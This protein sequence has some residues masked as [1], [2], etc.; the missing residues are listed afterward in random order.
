VVGSRFS[1]SLVKNT[2]LKYTSFEITS[3][4][5]LIIILVFTAIAIFDSVIVRYS[6]YT[7]ID[8]PVDLGVAIT[9]I[10][11][12]MY[13]VLGMSLLTS[14]KRTIS[15]HPRILAK[16]T[17]VLTY[18]HFIALSA[19]ILSVAII[20]VIILQIV[21]VE[22]YSIALLRVQT[23]L[24]HVVS[25][26]FL[27]YLVFRFAIW[28][29]TS[30]RDYIIFLYAVSCFLM[31]INIVVTL[32][33]LDSYFSSPLR[34]DRSWYSIVSIV[35]N[36]RVSPSTESLSVLFYALSLSSFLVMWIATSILLSQY[37]HR[38]GNVRYFLIM[39]VPV[40]YYIFPFQNYFGGTLIPLVL[41]S[42]VVFTILYIVIFSATNQ[43]GALVFSLSF[44]TSSKLLKDPQV[45]RAILMSS[46]GIAILFGSIQ[47]TP[48]QYRIYPPYGIITEAFMPLGAYA[49]LAG[50]FAA[51]TYI[52]QD[53][54]LRKE[55]YK[56]AFSQL[57]LFR[58]IG[59]SEMQRELEKKVQVVSR[60]TGS[61]EEDDRW[62]LK[63]EDAKQTLTEVLNEVYSKGNK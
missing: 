10:F 35:I 36:H 22:K 16:A 44:W 28:L 48:L 56:S 50:I 30:S 17:S 19:F 40:V 11:L 14:V 1:S 9:I 24:S 2:L 37:R 26:I 45:R 13:V 7:G 4:S 12:I 38:M 51:A 58:G 62:D 20:S 57:R 47:I 46:I 49:F 32:W 33:Y 55:F 3:R 29:K 6:A 52:S 23:Y 27:S 60:D 53:A 54:R 21:F 25:I 34:P 63:E 5:S 31:A 43:V 59:I 41:T 61:L 42:N 39:S 18:F 8:P 15:K